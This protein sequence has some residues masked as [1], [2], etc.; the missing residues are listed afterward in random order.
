MKKTMIF[1]LMMVL[2]LGVTACGGNEGDDTTATT[3]TTTTTT[4]AVGGSTTTTTAGDTT[5]TTT[6][7]TTAY[8]PGGSTVPI[9]TKPTTTVPTTTTTTTAVAGDPTGSGTSATTT[10]TTTTTTATTTTATAPTEEPLYIALPAVGTDID[11]AKQ[12]DRIHISETAAW[13]NDDGTVGV[14]LT[15]KNNSKNWITEETDWVQYTCYDADG[16]VLKT[17]R[18]MLG[19][20][21]TKKHAIK[22][23]EIAV[24]ANTAEVRL[25]DSKI[26][27][28]TEWA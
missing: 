13:W 9:G 19:S 26:V 10:T 24:P 25:T 5:T 20:I 12:K 11:V 4:E 14:A 21:D 6:E 22:T 23:F 3:T 17:D 8:V 18:I 16:K 28:W 15:V 7:T 27:Y 1:L 2:L